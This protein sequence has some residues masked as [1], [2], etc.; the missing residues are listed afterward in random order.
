[1]G[2][3]G[4]HCWWFVSGSHDEGALDNADGAKASCLPEIVT[5]S[6]V[7]VLESGL[8]CISMPQPREIHTMT[9]PCPNEP[10][11]VPEEMAVISL[12]A[13]PGTWAGSGRR[14]TA[15]R[16]SNSKVGVGKAK[17]GFGK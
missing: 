16:K 12:C 6:L 10:D 11:H 9:C 3:F 14:V 5:S 13:R 7:H 15:K 1:M 8:V 17:A 4:L 2:D